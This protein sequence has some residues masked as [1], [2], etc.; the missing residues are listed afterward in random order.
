MHMSKENSE[1]PIGHSFWSA[2]IAMM[3]F[4]VVADVLA[5]GF[6]HESLLKGS[7]EYVAVTAFAIAGFGVYALDGTK[8][9]EFVRACSLHKL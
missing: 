2:C 3:T 8:R 6:I 7:I 5:G 9:L 4:V 1:T